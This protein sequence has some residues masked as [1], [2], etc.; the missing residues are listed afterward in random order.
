VGVEYSKNMRMLVNRGTE[1]TFTKPS[2]PKSKEP[3]GGELE[4]YKMELSI[5][6]KAR[7]PRRRTPI[8]KAKFSLSSLDSALMQ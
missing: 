3:S 2:H 8:I 6:H 5:H 7:R 1:K 4:E